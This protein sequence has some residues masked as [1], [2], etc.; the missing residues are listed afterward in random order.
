MRNWIEVE[1]LDL[2][3]SNGER[4]TYERLASRGHGAVMIIPVLDDN[5]IL[6]INEY[7]A[8]VHEYQ[9][10]LP[11]GLVDPGETALEAAN[12]E[13][14]EEAICFGWIDTTIRRLDEKFFISD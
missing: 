4:R 11:K 6:L 12:R 10:T 8:G 3:F 7:A 14:M 5:T 2:R 1:E 13:L 9:L